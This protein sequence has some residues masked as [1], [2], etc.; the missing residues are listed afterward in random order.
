LGINVKKEP[1]GGLITE[2]DKRKHEEVLV[3]SDAIRN[4]KNP[5]GPLSN[6]EKKWRN[7]INQ[8]GSNTYKNQRKK[9]YDMRR[10]QDN[11][12]N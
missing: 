8:F 4:P 10:K 2:E 12:N 6:K 7:F 11:N 9:Q 3:T 1:R 5:A